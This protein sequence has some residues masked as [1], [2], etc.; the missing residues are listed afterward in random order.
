MA[1]GKR[2]FGAV[3]KLP[4][5][6]WRVRY[7]DPSGQRVTAPA[8][9]K[10]KADAN[11][12]LAL[13]QADLVRGQYIAP[14]EGRTT[15]AEW[16][17]S[18]LVRPGKR[19]ASVARDT[20]AV[21]V[22][23]PRLGNLT[24]STITPRD[25]QEAVDERARHA[26]PATVGRDFAA[27]RALLNAAVDADMIARS[28]ARKIALPRIVRPER[29]T[30]EAA[31]LRQLVDEVPE[32][33][34]ALVLTAGILGLAWEEVIALRVRDVDFMR[35]TVT[36]AQTVEE[37]AG[38]LRIVPEGKRPARLRT[39][40]APPFLI[41]AISRHLAAFRAD[42]TGDPEA[43]L[44]LGPRGG[45]LRR[46]FGERILRP[47]AKRAGLDG[48]TFHGLRHAAT[49]SLVDI[50]VHPRVMATRIGHGTARTTMEVYARASDRA[51]RE[52]ADLLQAKF[53][54][55]FETFRS[56]ASE[57]GGWGESAGS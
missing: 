41:E 40:A 2:Q 56:S 38:H 45:V 43:L 13:T 51:D 21:G 31:Q 19:A 28:P 50:G 49:S 11:A 33:Y 22:F 44:F 26:K 46:R 36:V 37:L 52:A 25:V 1:T 47:A 30:L 12:F 9:F 8:T 54:A 14:R 7:R 34:R 35:R 55:A 42:S 53:A 3:D 10:T 18:W 16:A 5:G 27:L 20:Q 39:M 57:K 15:L 4:S 48:L 24:L 32:H 29:M 23:L 17:E 6:R